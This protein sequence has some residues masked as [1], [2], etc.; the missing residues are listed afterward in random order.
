MK[1][2]SWIFTLAAILACGWI[3]CGPS[4]KVD[5]SKLASSFSGSPS[6][7]DID[8]AVTAINSGDYAAVVTTFK[9]VIKAA[10]GNLSQEQKDAMTTAITGMQM[11][12]SQN[13]KRYT[14]EVYQSLSD[15]V[16]LVEGQEPP[17][18]KP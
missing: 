14:V 9:K 2:F 7:S 6:K 10:A 15:L 18:R 8:Q 16:S 3:G 4:I 5:T 17:T 1:H 12:A 11:V 13:P